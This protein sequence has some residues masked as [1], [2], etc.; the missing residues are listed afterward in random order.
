MYLRTPKERNAVILGFIK[1]PFSKCTA[2]MEQINEHVHQIKHITAVCLV[3]LKYHKYRVYKVSSD[4]CYLEY[5]IE[6]C[7]QILVIQTIEGV[8]LLQYSLY[9]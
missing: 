5:Q 4:T 8:Y 1:L 6:Y 2:A 3:V 7:L 9:L